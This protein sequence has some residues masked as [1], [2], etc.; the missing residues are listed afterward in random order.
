MRLRSQGY[1]SS[2]VQPFLPIV[3]FKRVQVS[4]MNKYV[5][6]Y[7][8]LTSLLSLVQVSRFFFTFFFTYPLTSC[9]FTYSHSR[10]LKP[11]A[12]E[13]SALPPD[14]SSMPALL[15]ELEVCFRCS[16]F[17]KSADIA[18]IQATNTNIYGT[19]V[20]LMF[21]SRSSSHS[22]YALLVSRTPHPHHQNSANSLRWTTKLPMH[23][24]AS[25]SSSF[26]TSSITFK[27]RL[28][29]T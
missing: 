20:H 1:S 9:T 16:L 14:I 10:S 28:R 4:N 29:A 13:S 11:M 21:L 24:T 26:W 6:D 3:V 2:V 18:T 7:V 23:S 8:P 27:M 15:F 19:A 12:P 22:D 17:M 5:S 25:R